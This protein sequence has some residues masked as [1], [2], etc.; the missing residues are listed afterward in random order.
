MLHLIA[1]LVLG[2]FAGYVAGKVMSGHGYGIVGDVVLGVVG[3]WIGGWILS[4]FVGA[5]PSGA[6]VE[7][8]VS[9]LFACI[10]VALLHMVRHEP[11]RP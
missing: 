10:L 11:I 1:W 7:F 4:L 8:I 6:I 3:G 5:Q 9:V 2:G